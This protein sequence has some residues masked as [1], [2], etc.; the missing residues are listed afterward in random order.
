MLILSSGNAGILYK[1]VTRVRHQT[2]GIFR[3]N[4]RV[5]RWRGLSGA[6]PKHRADGHRK[7]E[8]PRNFHG[9]TP[10]NGTFRLT[11]DINSA[12]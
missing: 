3:K 8:P 11:C 5:I 1:P 4:I 2:T 9:S 10:V 12:S 7:D 6:R